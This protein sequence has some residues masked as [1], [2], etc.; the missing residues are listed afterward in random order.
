MISVDI[1]DARFFFS[2][3]K[4]CSAGNPADAEEYWDSI[5]QKHNLANRNKKHNTLYFIL[6]SSV[7]TETVCKPKARFCL[8]KNYF[9]KLLNH[10]QVIVR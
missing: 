6:D 1:F 9:Y 2:A 5:L 3:P 8:K 7:K 4:L 10:V